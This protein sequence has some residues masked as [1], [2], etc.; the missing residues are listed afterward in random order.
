MKISIVTPTYNRSRYLNETIESVLSQEGDFELEYII[1][2]GGSEAGVRDIIR[3]WDR[4]LKTGEFVPRCNK[5]EFTY[6]AETDNGMYD[7]INRGFA[8]SGGDV[9][10]WINSDDFYLPHAFN[11]LKSIFDKFDNIDWLTGMQTMYNETGGIIQVNFSNTPAYSRKFIREGFYDR[12]LL[13]YGLSWI[14]QENTFW[15]RSLWEKIGSKINGNYNAA[16]DYYLWREFARHTDLVHV[17]SVFGGIRKHKDQKTNDLRAY[18]EE[19]PLPKPPHVLY[20]ML[21]RIVKI[22]PITR[23]ILFHTRVGK[24]GF[25]LL[26][27][28]HNW[29]LGRT[30]MWNLETNDWYIN[31]VCFFKK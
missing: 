2:D 16:G 6:F 5:I 4:K 20:R 29:Y 9:M 22:F 10:A 14:Q 31:Q 11:T 15:R 8:R 23:R 19:I 18:Y 26:G 1:Q 13:K 7:A 3:E 28:K 25:K 12:R 27:Q 24:L 17:Y 30:V 21:R